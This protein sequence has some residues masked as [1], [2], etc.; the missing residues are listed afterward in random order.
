MFVTVTEQEG[1]GTLGGWGAQ[2][3][4]RGVLS[5][6]PDDDNGDGVDGAVL[7]PPGDGP[8]SSLDKAGREVR[9]S[10][11]GAG[12]TETATRQVSGHCGFALVGATRF[13]RSRQRALPHSVTCSRRLAQAWPFLAL[14]LKAWQLQRRQRG[15]VACQ[16]ITPVLV[17]GLL[18]LLQLVIR[19]ELG[20]TTTTL[21]PSLPVPLNGNLFNKNTKDGSCA[22]FFY[23]RV[24]ARRA[25]RAGGGA[26]FRY[27]DGN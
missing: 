6:E 12:A 19:S 7:A 17:M 25:S 22:E 27:G 18:L 5:P 14:W 9:Q 23:V 15:Q 3:G 1:E 20:G 26:A 24:P 16:C 21:V 13:Y 4:A 11:D 2:P 10:Q 8:S